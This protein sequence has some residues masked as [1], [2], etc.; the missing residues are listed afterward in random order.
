MRKISFFI[1][2]STREFG[3][4]TIR[5][6]RHDKTGTKFL[7]EITQQFKHGEEVIMLSKLD[8]DKLTKKD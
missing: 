3:K 1:V 5:L 7:D 6:N 8:F 4:M 2:A